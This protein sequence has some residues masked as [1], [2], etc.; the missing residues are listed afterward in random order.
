MTYLDDMNAAYDRYND[1][2]YRCLDAAAALDTFGPGKVFDVLVGDSKTFYIVTDATDTTATVE[3]LWPENE[4]D[5]QYI[6]IIADPFIGA[7]GTFER[8][9]IEALTSRN[10]KLSAIFGGNRS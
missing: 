8:E 4:D 5:D 1:Y 10:D 3:I 9:R 7:G 6:E 2:L